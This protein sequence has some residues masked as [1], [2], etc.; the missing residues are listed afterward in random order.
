MVNTTDPITIGPLEIGRLIDEHAAALEIY[1]RQWSGSPADCVPEAFIELAWQS[2]LPIKLWR[3]NCRL[4]VK[5]NSR[6]FRSLAFFG[7]RDFDVAKPG[8]SSKDELPV[9]FPTSRCRSPVHTS[10]KHESQSHR[11]SP[12]PGIEPVSVATR[13]QPGGLVSMGGRSFGAGAG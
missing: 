12:C 13:Q 8:E 3:R 10:I 6:R 1:A 9:P 7:N 5:L 4:L 11:Q 2:G